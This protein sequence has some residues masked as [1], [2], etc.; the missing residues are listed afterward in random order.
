M[1]GSAA[2]QTTPSPR[3]P[4]GPPRSALHFREA[5]LADLPALV[6]LLADDV[7]GAAREDTGP[8]LDPGYAAAFQAIAADPNNRL[9]VG[10]LGD[11]DTGPRAADAV[12][13]FCQLTVIP[14]LSRRGR[15]RAQVE[16][17]RVRSDLR[18]RGL[19]AALMAHVIGE[20][21]TAG[22]GLIQLT[23]ATRRADAQRFYASLGFEA[24]HMG[25]KLDLL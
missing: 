5:R 20:A 15:A 23:T 22:C 2:T 24:S 8:I 21:R 7:L 1:T 9:I 19:G 13:A 10:T 12:A 17:V 3:P 14:C 18:G 16:S 4:A 11:D 6:A 25:M